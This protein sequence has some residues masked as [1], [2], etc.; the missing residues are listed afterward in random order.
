MLRFLLDEHVPEAVIAAAQALEP[1]IDIVRMQDVGLRS[2]PDRELIAW[3]TRE[4]RLI[5]SHDK[6]SLIGDAY[7]QLADGTPFPGVVA[8]S[9]KSSIGK[10][11]E[12]MV[13]VAL[14]HTTEQAEN[15]VFY[16]PL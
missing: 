10:L 4:D 16:S 1:T 15:Q 11:A 8:Y 9:D 7:S 6:N 13:M 12:D 3:A 14:M 2:R 5:V